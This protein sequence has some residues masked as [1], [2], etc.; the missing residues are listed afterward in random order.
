M[1]TFLVRSP[2]RKAFETS[3]CRIAQFEDTIRE[4]TTRIVVA[5]IT[6]QWVS[7]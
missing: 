3:N 5:L 7:M 6:G 2:L 4:R 1:K